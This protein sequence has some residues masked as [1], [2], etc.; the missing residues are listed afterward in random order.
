MA[1]ILFT[2]RFVVAF[3]IVCSML[4]TPCVSAA[5]LQDEDAKAGAVLFGSSGCP[6]C[7]GPGGVGTERAPSLRDVGKR[8]KD[9]QIRHQI[10]DGGR[11]MPPFGE[12]LTEEEIAR[13]SAFLQAKDAW[14]LVPPPPA[15]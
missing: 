2:S 11:M 7:H 3:G 14:N 10:H 9:E 6:Y 4:M 13:L 15:K 1:P 12:A 8:L 5:N